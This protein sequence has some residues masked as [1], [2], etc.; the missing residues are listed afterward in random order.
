LIR[1]LTSNRG[2][3]GP[4]PRQVSGVGIAPSLDALHA[5]ASSLAARWGELDD[6]GRLALVQ[7]IK[8]A[9]SDLCR[10]ARQDDEDFETSEGSLIPNYLALL[11]PRELE[12][13]QAIARGETTSTIAADFA[14]SPLTVRSHVKNVLSKLSVH[15]RV[16]AVGLWLR[17]EIGSQA[18][19]G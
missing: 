3:I 2:N 11:T 12:V 8:H 7:E 4:A 18:D 10:R 5:L 19:V 14:I 6:E 9:V 17:F 15:S 13:L 16:E 1:P